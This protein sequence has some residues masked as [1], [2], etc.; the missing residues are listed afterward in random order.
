M[1]TT[2]NEPEALRLLGRSHVGAP[3][4]Q[5]GGG[6]GS[7]RVAPATAQPPAA[8]T[9]SPSRKRRRSARRS[10]ADAYAVGRILRQQLHVDRFE[11][12][13]HVGVELARRYRLFLH[14]LVRDATGLSPENGG[15]PLTIS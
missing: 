2:M 12:G 3:A 9:G 14:V 8:K 5:G 4:P 6:Y 13:R 11:V 1:S 7:C 15:L 10:S